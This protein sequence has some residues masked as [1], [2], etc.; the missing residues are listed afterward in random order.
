MVRDPGLDGEDTG[1]TIS[2]SANRRIHFLL[3]MLIVE[4]LQGT[5]RQ[6]RSRL[7]LQ[8]MSLF[9]RCP[10]WPL[11]SR[12]G[13]GESIYNYRKSKPSLYGKSLHLPCQSRTPNVGAI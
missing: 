11:Y 8:A 13:L 7:G 10:S 3:D 9:M 2:S 4:K 12:P 6:M 1:W 5:P